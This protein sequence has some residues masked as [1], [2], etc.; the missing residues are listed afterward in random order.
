MKVSRMSVSRWHRAWKKSGQ[1]ALRA[2][3]K[4]GRK[5]LVNLR[6]MENVQAALRQGRGLTVSARI[7]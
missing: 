5:P 2:A 6:H 1:R 4:A 7:C 3:P